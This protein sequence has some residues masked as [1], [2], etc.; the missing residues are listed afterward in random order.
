MSLPPELIVAIR[1]TNADETAAT[2]QYLAVTSRAN[3]AEVCSHRFELPANLLVDLEPQW[4]LDKAAPRAF[5]DPAKGEGG[6]GEL[7]QAENEKL[8]QC[9]RRLYEL[10][11]G[12]GQAL[13]AFLEFNDAYRAQAR[14]TLAMHGNAAALWRLPW[15]YLHDDAGFLALQGRFLLSRWPYGL[16]ELDPPPA[17]LPLRILVVVSAPEDQRPLNTEK[18]IAAIQEALDEAVRTERVQAQYLDDATLEAI[19]QA[20]RSFQPHVL[21]YTGHGKYDEAQGRSTLAL[22]NEEGQ[23]RPAGIA[24]L[25]PYILAGRELRLVVLSGCQTAQTS[26]VDAFS[27]VATGLLQADLPAVLAMQFSILDSSGI[28]LAQAFYASL[29]GGDSV[30]QAVQAA[31]LALRDFEEGPGYDWGVPALYLRAR[32]D[33]RLVDAEGR[34][35]AAPPRR[36][37][38]ID[39]AGLPLPPHFV[40]RKAELRALRRALREPQVTAAFVR[41]IGGMGKSAVAA[42]LIERPGLALDGVLVI[43]CHKVDPLDI[44]AKLASFLAGQGVAGHAEAA[45]LLLDSTR[46]PAERARLAATRAAAR[47][48]LFV[49]DNFESVQSEP[50][51]PFGR[52][53]GG[54]GVADPTLR[55]LL[56]GLLAAP[57]RSL[58]LFTG[59]HRW[60]ALD[61]WLGRGTALELHL[62][63]LSA[64]QAIMLM[65]N[66]PRLRKQPRQAKVAMWRK[67]GG[68]PHSIELLEGWLASGRVSDL[69]ADPSLD[70]LLRQKWEEYFLTALL[71]R[72]APAQREALARLSIFRTALDD[73]EFSYAGVDA[74]AAQTWLDLSLAQREAGKAAVELPPALAALLDMLPASERRQFEA[75]ATYTIHPVVREY[76]L[77]ERSD[78]ERRELHRWAAAYHGR[79][80]VAMARRK[81]RPGAQAT[82]EQIETFAR[83]DQGVVGQ[84]V[85]RTDDMDEAHG[86][87]A[88][89][90]EWQHHLFA[91]GDYE[92]AD[93]IV[94]A[95]WAVLAR[96][97]QRDRAK[98]LLR[99]SIATLEGGNLAVAQGNLATLLT[100]EGKLDEALATYE[101]VY[102]TFAALDARQQMAAALGQM[103]YVY[104][105]QGKYPEAI[106]KSDQ[107]LAI[108]R[109]TGDEEG[110]AISLHQ[111]SMLYR[112]SEDYATALARSQEAEKLAR[113]VGNEA[114]VAA[115][116][117]E[118][119]L[120]YTDLAR[121][122][123]TDDEAAGHRG[124]AFQ[125]FQQSLAIKRRIGNEAGAGDS[126]AE[127]GRLMMYADQMRDAI[128]MISEALDIAR[129]LGDPVKTGIRLEQLGQIHERQGQY[130]AALEKY[131]EALGLYQKYAP[132]EVER[133]RRNIALLRGKMG[134]G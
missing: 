10:L 102:A 61:P 54:E 5:L 105:D 7:K 106:A 132:P 15:E 23:T 45:A 120:I 128:A 6:A 121:A 104:Q 30:S 8:A 56:E 34:G 86:A 89:A 81:V 62:G 68:H 47:R 71:A 96:W 48:Y 98:A 2:P 66:L 93:D 40:G 90:L 52:G 65:D 60:P 75:R 58:C 12:D 37:A 17:S 122:A 51:S 79:P 74:A 33:L 64:P 73:A 107:A 92:P 94:T 1:R 36:A 39:M 31:R 80:F 76:L 50:P 67:V 28:R 88:R 69:L 72:L 49:F 19:G 16:A 83:G 85:R 77:A 134:G 111:L 110:Q 53:A 123:G 127:L 91:A 43:H 131:E 32:G 124:Q 41:G 117:H 29:A 3:G 112:R 38:M 4:V 101:A 133:C 99:G 97:G 13:R 26:A 70:G 108:V 14:L 78:G 59:R 27:G 103:S 63:E 126:L 130:P 100:D 113:K 22:E 118:Q 57:W 129:R 21:H 109:A 115:T 114:H 11:F 35:G 20:V 9:G 125:R 116:L 44:P 24:E 84:M 46:P 87:M 25:K 95:V 42:K 119:G 55:G 82:E 18:E